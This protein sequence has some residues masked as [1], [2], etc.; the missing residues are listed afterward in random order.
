MASPTQWTGVWVDSGSWW[1]TGRPGVL[2]FMGSQRVGHD[3]ATELDWLLLSG[4]LPAIQNLLSTPRG[5]LASFPLLSRSSSSAGFGVCRSTSASLTIFLKGIHAPRR[6]LCCILLLPSDC[7][8]GWV[9][10]ISSMAFLLFFLEGDLKVK[11]IVTSLLCQHPRYL[12][13]WYL[14]YLTTCFTFSWNNYIST[15]TLKNT[16]RENNFRMT[17]KGHVTLFASA[18]LSSL[19]V[20]PRLFCWLVSWSVHYIDSL[21]AS[22]QQERC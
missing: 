6:S 10:S 17:K 20:Q 2:W 4:R 5:W 18:S 7:W 19:P 16:H 14:S 12:I 22:H 15:G 13:L 11:G 3:W 1:W 9:G 8:S 21:N